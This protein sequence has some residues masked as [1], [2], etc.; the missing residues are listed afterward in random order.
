MATTTTTA[1]GHDLAGLDTTDGE[2]TRRALMAA[3]EHSALKRLAALPLPALVGI[4]ITWAIVLLA[5]AILEQPLVVTALARVLPS[6]PDWQIQVG[7]AAYLIVYAVLWH[8]VGNRLAAARHLSLSTTTTGKSKKLNPAFGG[9]GVALVFVLTLAMAGVAVRRAL[10]LA[11]GAAQKAVTTLV[12]NSVNPPS[13]GDLARAGD[14]A[15]H[16]AFLPDLV[17]TLSLMV[18]LAAL[19]TWHGYRADARH[20]AVSLHLVQRRADAARRA[21][22][23]LQAAHLDMARRAATQE[24]VAADRHDQADLFDDALLER[25]EQAKTTVRHSLSFQ[26]GRPDATTTLATHQAPRPVAAPASGH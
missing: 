9:V 10:S 26:Q 2:R 16:T 24:S 1:A 20:H 4:E 7:A 17:F 5:A 14:Q 3:R 11:D 21:A 25:F 13:A 6:A 23:D 19:G 18:L 22:A 15:W 12:K 8:A